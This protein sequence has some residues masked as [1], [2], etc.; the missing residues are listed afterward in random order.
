MIIL[1]MQATLIGDRE[2]GLWYQSFPWK[3]L[4]QET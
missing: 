2:G 3:R 4:V 1:E